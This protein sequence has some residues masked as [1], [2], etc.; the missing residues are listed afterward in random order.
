M[1][2]MYTENELINQN[3]N[4]AANTYIANAKIQNIAANK[5]ANYVRK[6]E[7]FS[8]DLLLSKGLNLLDLGSG[9]GT[10]GFES[11]SRI[12]YDLS[13]KMLCNDNCK[14]TMAINGDAR[15]LPFA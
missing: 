13:Y 4:K 11:Y 5:V 3:F 8:Q 10:I 9:P 15:F 1:I 12:L 6:L 7:I 2:E 14:N